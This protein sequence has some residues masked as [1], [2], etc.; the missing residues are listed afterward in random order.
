MIAPHQALLLHTVFYL[1]AALT[2]VVS[3]IITAPHIAHRI[4]A[5]GP[6]SDDVTPDHG[7]PSDL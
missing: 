4:A 2:L 6:E 3:A 1:L 7:Q 5:Q